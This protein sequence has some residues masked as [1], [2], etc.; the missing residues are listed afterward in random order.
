[1]KL[2]KVIDLTSN[3]DVFEGSYEECNAYVSRQ[4]DYYNFAVVP[5]I[6]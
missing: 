4:G 1:M 3:I 2:Y 6:E 5:Y